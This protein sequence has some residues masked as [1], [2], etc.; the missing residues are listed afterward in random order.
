MSKTPTDDEIS[1]LHRWFAVRCNNRAWT[2][3][4]Q[5][6]RTVDDD[7]ELLLS[8]HAAAFHWRAIGTDRNQALSHVLLAHAYA[9]LGHAALANHYADRAHAFFTS[10]QSEAWE[11]AFAEAVKA[12]AAA[13]SAHSEA[14]AEHYARAAT[15]AQTLGTEDR[16]IFM[17]TF[18]RVPAP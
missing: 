11:L 6:V 3:T 2:L 9:L 13:I 17:A 5:P 14:H 8:A 16:E 15:L 18:A 1:T 7:D 4:E 12:H 10:A